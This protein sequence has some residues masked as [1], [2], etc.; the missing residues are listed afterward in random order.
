MVRHAV[1]QWLT[2]HHPDGDVVVA[3]SGGPD[4]LA[5]TAGAVAEGVGVHAVIVDHGLQPDSASVAADAARTADDIGCRTVRVVAVEVTGPGG[6]EAAARRARYD[7][8]DAA[9]GGRPI[10]LGHTLDDQAETVL[11]GLARGSGPRSLRGMIDHDPPHG[12]PLLAVRRRDTVGACRELGT[13][14]WLDPHNDD[15]AFTR[16]R[17]RAEVLP[18]LEDVLG[19]GVA[20]ALARTADQLREDSAVLDDL[21]ADAFAAARTEDG[22]DVT[23][24][25]ASPAP[26]RRRVVRSWLLAGGA[27]PR[28][29]GQIRAV[30]DLVGRWRG[31][32]EVAVGGGGGGVRLVALRRRGSLVL[33]HRPIHRGL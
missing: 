30:D 2:R 19:G 14:P 17:V 16:V 9:R 33:E 27:S 11:L 31:Q 22:L 23:V 28:T 29:D 20:S 8:L 10:L 6:P 12:R 1:R 25:A 21:A 7:A 26:V 4:S 24:L 5:L 32:G 3:L 18:L 15:P 13:T